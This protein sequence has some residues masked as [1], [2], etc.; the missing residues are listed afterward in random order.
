MYKLFPTNQEATKLIKLFVEQI[1]KHPKI[2]TYLSSKVKEVTGFIGNFDV[3]LDGKGG[4][5]KFNV[6]TIV[7]AT[8]ADKLK[9]VG[10][11]GYGKMSNVITQLEL[12]ERM[13]KGEPL[14][15]DSRENLLQ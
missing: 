6:G 7:V 2:K 14:G 15:A 11:Y 5:S 3:N 1:E 4:A 10:Q 8:G 9:P 12:E 13:K